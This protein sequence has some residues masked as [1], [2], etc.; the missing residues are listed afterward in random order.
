MILLSLFCSWN[1][2]EKLD[3]FWRKKKA[4]FPQFSRVFPLDLKED[5]V[6][7]FLIP[8]YVFLLVFSCFIV[9]AFIFSCGFCFVVVVVLFVA[10]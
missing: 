8:L 6:N 5:M 7:L 9:R 3:S 10:D 1:F 4:S 2:G